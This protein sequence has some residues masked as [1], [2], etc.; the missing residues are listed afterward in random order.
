[1]PARLIARMYVN[2]EGIFDLIEIIYLYDVITDGAKE[3]VMED[4]FLF[5][6]SFLLPNMCCL[7]ELSAERLTH[8]GDNETARFGCL[9]SLLEISSKKIDC[10]HTERRRRILISDL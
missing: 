6:C 10:H 9:C 3:A 1:M 4:S 2:D 7:T 8:R 5:P